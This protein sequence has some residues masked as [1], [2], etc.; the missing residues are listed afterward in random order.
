[1]LYLILEKKIDGL[2]DHFSQIAGIRIFNGRATLFGSNYRNLANFLTF[3]IVGTRK[4][5]LS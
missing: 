1:M 5:V 2:N 3:A 4:I